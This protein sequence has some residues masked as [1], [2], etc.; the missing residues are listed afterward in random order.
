MKK[1]FLK[2]SQNSEGNTCAR[3]F[4]SSKSSVMRA[5]KLVIPAKYFPNL[6]KIVI[7]QE[8]FCVFQGNYGGNFKFVEEF[9]L[10]RPSGHGCISGASLR[11]LIERFRDISKRADL[12]ISETSSWRLIRDAFSETSLRS[13][14]FSQ[15]RLSV[16]SETVILG[17]QTKPLFI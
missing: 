11:R 16:Q 2:I 17:F 8:W 7:Q 12:Q 5:L 10:S 13:L 9:M 15:R 6:G 3:V 1:V 4:F 14:R